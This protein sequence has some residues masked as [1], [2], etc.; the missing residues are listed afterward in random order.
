MINA[1]ILETW[2]VIWPEKFGECFVSYVGPHVNVNISS[3]ELLEV[4]NMKKNY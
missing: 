3:P 2:E 1:E 4:I